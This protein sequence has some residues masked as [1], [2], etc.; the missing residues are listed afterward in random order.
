M[1]KDPPYY[2]RITFR[3]TVTHFLRS[4]SNG[5]ADFDYARGQEGM[6]HYG[7]LRMPVPLHDSSVE[8]MLNAFESML[9]AHL[10]E[11]FPPIGLSGG[12]T[13]LDTVLDDPE[14]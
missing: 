2:K 4:A 11:V 9:R 10:Q 6:R 14:T 13:W 5:Q 7:T 8:G 3:L 12:D 1:P